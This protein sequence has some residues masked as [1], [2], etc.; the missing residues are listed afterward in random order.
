M[1]FL[2]TDHSGLNKFSGA[3]DP[4][5]KL[6]LAEIDS[7]VNSI[8]KPLSNEYWKVP[9]RTNKLFTGRT[10]LL[11]TIKLA[12]QGNE[13]DRTEMQRVFVVTGL[14]GQ[15]KSELCLRAADLMR[16]ECV[17]SEPTAD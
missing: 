11:E 13:S 5:F 8:P 4:N 1:M 2:S 10:E 16:E 7:I 17:L 12:L 14:G 3:D 15:G 9:R 6:V